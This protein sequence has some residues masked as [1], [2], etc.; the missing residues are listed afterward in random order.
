MG[1]IHRLWS[2]REEQHIL[3]SSPNYLKKWLRARCKGGKAFT[4]VTPWT[5]ID[6]IYTYEHTNL[7]SKARCVR[8]LLIGFQ[9]WYYTEKRWLGKMSAER[10][11]WGTCFS[12]PICTT[13]RVLKWTLPPSVSWQLSVR[14]I[15][16]TLSPINIPQKHYKMQISYFLVCKV[17]LL[18]VTIS[19]ASTP[20]TFDLD[21]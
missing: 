14:H 8:Q 13:S 5:D 20:H 15:Q 9:A 19:I 17:G 12:S 21:T 4:E 10:Y 6:D 11:E 18:M 7:R 16:F 1:R 2:R 3:N